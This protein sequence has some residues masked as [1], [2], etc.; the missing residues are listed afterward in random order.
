MFPCVVLLLVFSCSSRPSVAGLYFWK[1]TLDWSQEDTRRLAE[2]GVDRV[3]L[4]LFDWGLAGE[5]GPLV[6][7]SPLP[8]GVMVVPVVYVTTGRLESWAKAPGFRPNQAARDLL[9]HIDAALPLA[10]SGNPT[11]WQLDADWT[12][13]TRVAW[14]AVAA[15]FRDLVHD[16]GGRFEV[17][18]RLHQYRDRGSQGVPPA[19]AGVLMLYGA[20][21]AVLDP[22]LVAGYLTGPAYPLPLV[23][24]FPA[25]T[26][27]RQNNGYGRL[28]ALHRLHAETDLPFA[29]LRLEGPGHYTV[30]RRSSLGGRPLLDHD[31]LFVDRVEPAVLDAVSELSAVTALRRAAGDRVWI[32]DY[33]SQGWEALIHGPLAPHLFPR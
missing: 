23:P 14:F 25:Y 26:Q 17:T 7:R 5:E 18:V 1:T 24:A 13:S 20:G 10:W 6:V 19:D 30:V 21:D 2:A 3:G 8:A 27:V 15:G 9:D 31:E 32:F 29:D 33:D 16:R 12:A 22:N 11:V 28:V 4:R